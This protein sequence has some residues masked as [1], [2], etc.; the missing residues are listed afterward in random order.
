MNETPVPPNT[1][2][3][4]LH[5]VDNPSRVT[6]RVVFPLILITNTLPL[7]ASDGLKSAVLVSNTP[8]DVLHKRV[9]TI[10]VL[11][12]TPPLAEIPPVLL[13]S[14]VEFSVPATDS[15]F[16]KV[17]PPEAEMPAVN[18][19]RA[20]NVFAFASSATVP[21]VLGRVIVL[22]LVAVL[23]A[24]RV[25]VKAVVGLPKIRLTG[26]LLVRESVLVPRYRFPPEN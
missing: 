10:G 4:A 6:V 25:V 26:V 19:C 23:G 18:D 8:D 7:S 5:P 2:N 9:E 12:V 16:A 3:F 14:P 13:R 17:T 21:V 22:L 1:R 11:K 24:V 20:V 15:A